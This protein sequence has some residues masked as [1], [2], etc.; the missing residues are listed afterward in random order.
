MSRSRLKLWIVRDA[1][2]GAILEVDR[3]RDMAE[4]MCAGYVGTWSGTPEEPIYTQPI[5]ECHIVQLGRMTRPVESVE[6]VA[7]RVERR[8]LREQAEWDQFEAWARDKKATREGGA[9]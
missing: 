4:S 5:L 3:D 6:T 8:K 1:V 9:A 7:P 2:D